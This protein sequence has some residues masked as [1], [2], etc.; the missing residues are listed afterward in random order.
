MAERIP[1]RI[2]HRVSFGPVKVA[3]MGDKAI[4]IVP[5]ALRLFLLGKR[6]IVHVVVLE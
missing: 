5:K 4:I 6:V 3:K 2:P 1:E